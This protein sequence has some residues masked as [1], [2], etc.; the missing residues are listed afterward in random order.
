MKRTQILS[1]LTLILAL[2]LVF[3]S[4]GA[5]NGM[6][7]DK[8]TDNF[9]SESYIDKETGEITN[10]GSGSRGDSVGENLDD[11]KIIKNA[12]MTVQTKTF[13]TFIEELNKKISE[14]EGY[15]QNSSLY[16]NS[17]STNGNRSAQYT[18]RIPAENLNAF[19]DGVTTLGNVTY[20]NESAK[21]VTTSYID[22][23][24]R[25]KALET[26]QATLLD[27]L[28]KSSDLSSL[29]K[30]QE[31]LTEVNYELENYKSQLRSYDSRI[32][33]STV[34]IEIREV[35]R[36]TTVPSKQ[37]LWE[38]IANDFGNNI[39]DIANGAGDIFVWFVS[40]IPYLILVAI[41]T[42]VIIVLIRRNIKKR[43]KKIIPPQLPKE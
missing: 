12:E 33:Y 18:V 16:G 9:Y 37:T 27:L 43:K 40:S 15:I 35:E 8:G 7:L 4:C 3:S 25:I 23:E 5:S 34:E 13:D 11:R 10:I 6:T 39:K 19:K 30:V 29:L 26:E 24:S 2:S 38:R 31:R 14:C 20:Y 22:T 28:T 21:D 1:L 17:Y 41:P 42:V 36:V 32:S